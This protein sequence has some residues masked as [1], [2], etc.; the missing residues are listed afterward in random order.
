MNLKLGIRSS[1]ILLFLLL[2]L[3]SLLILN[4]FFINKQLDTNKAF[5]DLNFTESLSGLSFKLDSDSLQAREL[6]N[7]FNEAIA[8]TDMMQHETQI[9]SSVFL[10]LMMILSIIVFIII[11]YKITRP[12]KDLHVATAKIR[13]G[14]FSVKI[15]EKGIKEIKQLKQSFNLMSQELNQT[16]QKLIEAEKQ[17]LWKELSRILAHEIKNPLTPIQLSLQRLEEKYLENMEKFKEIFPESLQIINQEIKNLQTLARSFSSFAKNIDADLRTFDPCQIIHDI[18]KSYMHRFQIKVESEDNCRIN[19]DETHFYQIITN[20]LQ[21]A[22]DASDSD[23]K[24]LITI[25]NIDQYVR[26]EIIDKGKGIPTKDID[27]IFE[28]YFT[29]KAKG[30]GLG[31][32][33]VKKLIDLN[34]ADI[35]IKSEMNRGSTVKL[36]IKSVK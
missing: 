21:N 4:N 6:L 34:N 36:L 13:Q 24:I 20:I 16:Q 27:K 7:K 22:I 31:L 30:T 23:E 2:Y 8:A 5:K 32:A 10:F 17:A 33:L 18:A 9:Y 15:P 35:S 26:I 3:P 28:P 25:K 29:N 14:D 1:V 19:F 12:L 11:F